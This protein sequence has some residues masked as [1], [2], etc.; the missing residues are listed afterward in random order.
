MRFFDKVTDKDLD[1]LL[2]FYLLPACL[3]NM[4]L[5]LWLVMVYGR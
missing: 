5:L 1:N 4:I 3:V 2:Y